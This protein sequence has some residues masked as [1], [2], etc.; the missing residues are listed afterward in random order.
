MATPRAA[1]QNQVEPLEKAYKDALASAKETAQFK[2]PEVIKQTGM[3]GDLAWSNIV[4]VKGSRITLEGRNRSIYLGIPDGLPADPTSAFADVLEAAASN[5]TKIEPLFMVLKLVHDLDAMQKKVENVNLG[6]R[7][8]LEQYA[9]DANLTKGIY[10][11]KLAITEEQAPSA[12]IYKNATAA[13][14][15]T[16]IAKVVEHLVYE[17][18]NLANNGHEAEA[19]NITD[20]LKHYEGFEQVIKAKMQAEA[21]LPTNRGRTGGDAEYKNTLIEAYQEHAQSHAT[22]M[23]TTSYMKE[24]KEN[25]LQATSGLGKTL[26]AADA[27]KD[28]ASNML[29]K[30]ARDVLSITASYNS[31]LSTTGTIKKF[32]GGGSKRTDL[33]AMDLETIAARHCTGNIDGES[34]RN[35][36]VE[37]IEKLQEH[38]TR[39]DASHDKSKGPS[40]MAAAIRE[41]LQQYPEFT[42]AIAQKPSPTPPQI[43]IEAKTEVENAPARLS[44]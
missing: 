30:F 15:S 7:E 1:T 32:F 35:V 29:L 18:N 9:E 13:N 6:L 16:F 11:S 24:L 3:I 33:M 37:M 44:R 40:K 26:I 4:N 2:S 20:C 36:M 5:K 12:E 43:T 25:G 41:C 21:S 34:V 22:Q 38:L 27:K 14:V 10:K 42:A 17:A 31:K 19:K 39:I 28:D 23:K 8:I